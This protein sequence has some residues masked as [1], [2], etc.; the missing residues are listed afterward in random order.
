MNLHFNLILLWHKVTSMLFCQIT[1][2]FTSIPCL[3]LLWIVFCIQLV[4][5][6][7]LPTP[8]FCKCLFDVYL[9]IFRRSLVCMHTQRIQ[10][11]FY[12]MFRDRSLHSQTKCP[13]RPRRC[14]CLKSLADLY[15]FTE[16][17][18][19]CSSRLIFSAL[20]LLHHDTVLEGKGFRTKRNRLQR[21][22]PCSGK[23]VWV[24]RKH[25]CVNCYTDRVYMTYTHIHIVVFQHSFR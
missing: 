1:Y 5:N 14:A 8:L 3:Q 20:L 9:K 12:P 13:H 10:T 6:T 4:Y 18:K 24:L 22:I 19:L 21:E 7:L 11:K 23:C 25:P 2:F 16:V 17:S 15:P